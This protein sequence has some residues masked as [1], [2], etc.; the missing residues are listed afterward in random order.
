MSRIHL[1][2]SSARS[3]QASNHAWARLHAT[4]S[5]ATSSS[6]N[7]GRT[8]ACGGDAASTSRSLASNSIKSSQLPGFARNC[9]TKLAATNSDSDDV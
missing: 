4:P 2:A 7:G 8:G 9:Y 6:S 3:E 5:V 1:S